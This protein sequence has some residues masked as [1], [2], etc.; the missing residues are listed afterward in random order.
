[1]RRA[2]RDEPPRLRKALAALKYPDFALFWSAAL[3]SN[4]GTWIQGVTVPYVLYQLTENAAWVG[5]ATFAQF[6]P[7][8]LLGPL[9]GSLADRFPRRRV[10]LITQSLLAGAALT[11]WVVWVT[12]TTS[13]ALLTSLLMLS[14][15][16]AGLNIPSWQAFVTE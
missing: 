3:V 10:L 5:F 1:M 7:A 12:G 11:L 6:L 8:V 9:A 15:V 14:G 16:F 2:E 4:T 13:P